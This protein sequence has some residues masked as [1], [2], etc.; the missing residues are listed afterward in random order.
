MRPFTAAVCG[1]DEWYR[2]SWQRIVFNCKIIFTAADIKVLPGW[3]IGSLSV[4][5]L[6]GVAI[7]PYSGSY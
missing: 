5:R 4:L 6:Q 3:Q 2:S 7:L 1:L